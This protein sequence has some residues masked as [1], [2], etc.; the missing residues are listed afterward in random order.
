MPLPNPNLYRYHHFT[1][2]FCPTYTTYLNGLD[3]NVSKYRAV[4]RLVLVLDILHTIQKQ[5]PLKIPLRRNL[6][7]AATMATPPTREAAKPIHS[8]I[9]D[10][11]PLIKNDPSASALVAQAEKLYI[12]PS[13]IPE[14]RDTATRTR[15]ETTLLPFVTVR[16]PT[17]ASVKFIRDFARK[18]GDLGVLSKPDIEVLALGYELECERNNGDWRLR[19]TPGQKTL[20]GK[21]PARAEATKDEATS[22]EATNSSEPTSSEPI[23]SEP[24]VQENTETPE[25]APTEVLEKLDIKDEP[26]NDATPVVESLAADAA[27]EQAQDEDS[28]AS[29]G[30]ASDEEGGWITPSNLKKHKAKDTNTSTPSQTP[31]KTLQAAVL[32]SDYAMQNVAL[33]MNL[34][35]ITPNFSRITQ[36]K[37][38]VLRCHG[39]F[40]ITKDMDKQFCPSCGQPTLLRTSCSTDDHGNF[41]VHLKQNFQWNNRGNVY[42]V[43]KPTHGTANGRLAKNAGGQNNW[44]ASLMFAE[45]Q[46][47]YMRASDAQRKAKKKDLM[48]DDYL[49][50]I[51]SGD[52]AGGGK[53]KVG[54]GRSVNSKKKR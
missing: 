23:P 29:D 30:D 4:I 28:E 49:P 42:S 35:L 18:T 3:L 14:I 9:L 44:G 10:T 11:G 21:P 48:D 6:C 12:L 41:R 36:L 54:A 17:P 22:A 2:F 40:K 52:R 24:K 15:V 8:L 45:D 27:A 32:T 33:R 13:V 20:N 1:F 31:Q 16:S 37:T 25:D 38:W 26:T 53:I 34:N 46:K 19:N 7:K 39:C 5:I 51:L 50:N 47:E 43:P